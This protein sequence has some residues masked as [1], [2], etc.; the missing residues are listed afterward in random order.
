MERKS[1]NYAGVTPYAGARDSNLRYYGDRFTSSAQHLSAD[2][3]VFMPKHD[4]AVS[5]MQ[6]LNCNS[7]ADDQPTIVNSSSTASKKGKEKRLEESQDP[8]GA[9]S[10]KVL[11]PPARVTFTTDVGPKVVFQG[12]HYLKIDGVKVSELNS[13][14]QLLIDDV[15]ALSPCLMNHADFP[16]VR[17]ERQGYSCR[18]QQG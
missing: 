18:L 12:G 9:K 13:I 10:R 14:F 6:Y 8:V 11:P 5:P 4:A 1:A 15:S 2:A 17:L 16:A 3:T 7:T